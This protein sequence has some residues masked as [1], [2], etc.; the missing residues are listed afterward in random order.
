M[1]PPRGVGLSGLGTRSQPASNRPALR[2]AKAAVEPDLRVAAGSR[3]GVRGPFRLELGESA[4]SPRRQAVGRLRLQ[5][6][7]VRGGHP[8][9][10]VDE[11]PPRGLEAPPQIRRSRARKAGSL[12]AGRLLQSA[13]VAA[14]GLALGQRPTRRLP[15]GRVVDRIGHGGPKHLSSALSERPESRRRPRSDRG[16]LYELVGPWHRE[17]LRRRSPD[18]ELAERQSRS[19]AY[20]RPRSVDLVG[21]GVVNG[22][23]HRHLSCRSG[24]AT[25][26]LSPRLG[27]G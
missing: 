4:A 2:T 8:L 24:T 22:R 13:H 11:P 20:G 25:S 16:G 14:L 19:R 12:A 3:R 17:D 7:Q 21:Q 9:R 10:A 1:R 18:A 23:H 27:G 6:P 5:V 26:P 15:T